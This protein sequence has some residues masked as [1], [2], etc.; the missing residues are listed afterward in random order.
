LNVTSLRCL[1]NNE[2]LLGQAGKPALSHIIYP[3]RKGISGM[4]RPT[5]TEK[6]WRNEFELTAEDET[7]LQED[8]FLQNCPLSTGQISRLLMDW[9]LSE[10]KPVSSGKY[11]STEQYQVGQKIIFAALDDDIGE[12][13]A[14][15]DGENERYGSFRVIKVYFAEYDETREFASELDPSRF[16]VQLS[17]DP[18]EGLLSSEELYTSFGSIVLNSIQEALNKSANFVQWGNDWISTIILVPYNQGHLHIAD[19]MIDIMGSAMQTT[20]LLKEIPLEGEYAQEIKEFSLNYI[21]SQD[22]RFKNVGT[23]SEPLWYLLRLI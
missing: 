12:V 21:L 15:R 23:Q 4:P 9:R 14:I 22:T 2:T 11:S 16:E 3:L 19:A 13:M 8:F 7:D 6:Y 20:E 5:Q 1:E 18:N 10:D 17:D